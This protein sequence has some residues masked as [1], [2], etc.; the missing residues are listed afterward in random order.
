M[1]KRGVK[2]LRGSQMQPEWV[3]RIAE[4]MQNPESRKY[5]PGNGQIGAEILGRGVD[6][7]RRLVVTIDPSTLVLRCYEGQPDHTWLEIL[8][9][10]ALGFSQ[11]HLRR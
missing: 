3:R 4:L 6:R 1:D 7:I 8:S 11:P 10:S 9:D 2:A 5:T